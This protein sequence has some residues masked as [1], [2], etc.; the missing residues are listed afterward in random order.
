MAVDPTQ[1]DAT[2]V[3]ITARPDDV[4]LR[5]PDTNPALQLAQSLSQTSE[6]L[7]PFLNDVA[8]QLNARATAKA[9]ADALANSGEAFADAVREGKI[10]ATQNPWYMH[11]YEK[12]SAQVRAQGQVSALVTQMQSDPTR[13]DPQAFAAKFNQNLGQIA[14]N[15]TGLNA[16]LGFHAAADPLA[17]QAL[18]QNTEYNVQRIQQEHVQNATT[19]TTQAIMDTLKGNPKASPDTLFAATDAQH[20]E[21]IGVGGTEPQWRLLLKQAFVGAGSNLGDASVL[22]TLK[23]PYEGG[24]PIA[25]QADETGKPTGLELA[26]DKFWIDRG[27]DATLTQAY[28]SNQAQI[29]KDGQAVDAWANQ[30]YGN[31]YGLGKIPQSQLVDD[32]IAQGYSANA[33]NWA[34]ARQGES[35]RAAAGY[36]S[37]QTDIYSSDPAVQQRILGVNNEAVT[38]GLTP[39]L[40]AQLQ[41]MLG[42]HQ[43]TIEMA[44]AVMDRAEGQSHFAVGEANQ[45]RREAASLQR[46]DAGLALQKWGLVGDAAKSAAAKAMVTLT[47]Y[48][49]DPGKMLPIKAQEALKTDIDNAAMAAGDKGPAAAQEAAENAAAKLI[50]SYVQRYKPGQRPALTNPNDTP[51]GNK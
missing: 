7:H 3:D 44:N 39:K 42:R 11:A 25:N 24:T 50:P 6:E 30:K 26:S 51:P 49:I 8:G 46:A 47:T 17:E 9:N 4:S 10:E 43:I 29:A 21:W 19:L 38:G 16:S 37:A 20:K 18:N 2:Q 27:V 34:M 14:E 13:N 32:A 45:N 36:S 23:A 22:D 48:G 35:L 5:A 31:D 12:A 1:G 33:I 15:F 40:T 41:D 28:K